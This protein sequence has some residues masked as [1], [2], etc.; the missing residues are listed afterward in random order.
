M[1]PKPA[2]FQN[3]LWWELDVW[4]TSGLPLGD[5]PRIAAWLAYNKSVGDTFTT[6]ELRTALGQRLSHSSR[7]DREHFQRRIRQLRGARDGWVFPS[8]KHDRTVLSGTYRLDKVGW[9]PAKGDRP[10]DATRVSKRVRREVLSRDHERCFHCG[11]ISGQPYPDFPERTATMT[12]GHV[13]PAD[14][15]GIAEPSNLRAECALCNESIRSATA[16]PELAQGVKVA[17][18]D[19][20]KKDRLELRNWIRAGH[21]IRNKV[22]VTYDRFRQLTTGDKDEFT[23]WLEASS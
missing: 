5:E 22:D 18:N 9:H 23:K 12:V 3:T 7:N 19:L 16:A 15:G 8:A 11:V 6:D 4:P 13:T 17:A 14:F 1:Y 10:R 21:R 2:Y 20:N